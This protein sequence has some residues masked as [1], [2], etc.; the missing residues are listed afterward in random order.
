[1]RTSKQ[2]LEAFGRAMV[3]TPSLYWT[4]PVPPPYWRTSTGREQES[5]R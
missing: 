5:R 4:V 3:R 1:M 2:I